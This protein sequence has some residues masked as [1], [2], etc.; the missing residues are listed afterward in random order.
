MIVCDFG[1]NMFRKKINDKIEKMEPIAEFER[2]TFK[3]V[4]GIGKFY[5]GLYSRHIP[6]KVNLFFISGKESFPKNHI[7]S[8]FIHQFVT[9]CLLFTSISK[10]KNCEVLLSVHE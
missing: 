8:F 4:K 3:R 5:T 10:N 6:Q 9:R 2:M 1:V 7:S